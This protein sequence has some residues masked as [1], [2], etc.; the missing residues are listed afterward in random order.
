MPA[1]SDGGGAKAQ[2]RAKGV[3]AKCTSLVTGWP[4][5][6]SQGGAGHLRTHAREQLPDLLN[7]QGRRLGLRESSDLSKDKGHLSSHP[8]KGRSVSMTRESWQAQSRHWH[9]RG[10]TSGLP[11]PSPPPHPPP[12]HTPSSCVGCAPHPGIQEARFTC[13]IS[14]NLEA[15]LQRIMDKGGGLRNGCAQAHSPPRAQGPQAR[16]EHVS[17]PSLSSPGPPPRLCFPPWRTDPQGRN[18]PTRRGWELLFLR[19]VEFCPTVSSGGQ[20]PGCSNYCS[21]AP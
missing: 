6:S 13:I 20:G 8:K 19:A 10:T 15:V 16:K 14:F 17:S 4:G 18:G 11:S 2:R 9:P 3:T 1:A 7:C 21:P 12:A 5:P